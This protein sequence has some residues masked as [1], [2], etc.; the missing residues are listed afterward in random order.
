MFHEA[1][2][3][4]VA[5]KLKP[6][7]WLTFFLTFCNYAKPLCFICLRKSH[8]FNT[9]NSILFSST[10]CSKTVAAKP[11]C[12]SKY[13]STILRDKPNNLCNIDWSVSSHRQLVDSFSSTYI[14]HLHSS[15]TIIEQILIYFFLLMDRLTLLSTQLTHL[16]FFLPPAKQDRKTVTFLVASVF[17]GFKR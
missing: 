17:G 15:S 5:L 11:T 2:M 13:H 12:Q 6:F 4:K 3:P 1:K 7:K 14:W 16:P 9:V 8:H 10:K